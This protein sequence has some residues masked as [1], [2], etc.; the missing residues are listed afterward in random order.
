MGRII[1]LSVLLFLTFQIFG[2][3]YRYVNT[4]ALNIREKAGKQFNVI[5]LLNKGDSVI[6]LSRNGSWTEIETANGI[7]GYVSAEY[8]STSNELNSNSKIDKSFWVSLLFLLGVLGFAIYKIRNFFYQIFGSNSASHSSK[9]KS[10]V[11]SDSRLKH[12][13][14]FFLSIRDGAVNLGKEKSTMRQSVFNHFDRAIDCDLEDPKNN[15]S[16][17]LVVTTKGEVILCKLESTGKDFVFRPSASYGAAYKAKFAESNSF[18]FT[19]DE[20]TFKGYFNSTRKD[21][22]S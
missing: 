13:D 21:R 1:I 6:I 22:L 14:T 3:E 5:G 8:L 18:I 9:G 12:T 10:S 16:R 7:K 17:F 19:T 2:Q 4:E 11:K 15:R 20:G